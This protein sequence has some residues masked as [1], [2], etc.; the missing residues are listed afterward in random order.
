MMK[1][2]AQPAAQ[3]L[4]GFD[5]AARPGVQLLITQ[6]TVR[7]LEGGGDKHRVVSA[8]YGFAFCIAKDFSWAILLQLGD[9]E[10]GESGIDRLPTHGVR[11]EER[12]VAPHRLVAR[13]LARSGLP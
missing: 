11:E 10:A 4:Q 1:L 12:E 2:R 7:R 8:G 5:D 13:Q 6:G 3:R 9:V